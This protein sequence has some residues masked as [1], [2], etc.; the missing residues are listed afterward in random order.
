MDED[1]GA[2][3]RRIVET[4]DYVDE[5]GKLL[6]QV[7][8]YEPKD[9]RQ[10]RPDP[11]NAGQWLWNL[12]GVKRVPYRLPE[13]QKASMQDWTI[14]AEGEKDADRLCELGFT[15]TTCPMGAGKWSGD[16]NGYFK[17]RLVAIL[18]DNDEAGR[19]HTQRFYF[20]TRGQLDRL[21]G[22]SGGR[23]ML[24]VHGLEILDRWQ[25]SITCK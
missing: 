1:T 18:P 15:A 20:V 5:S 23:S 24:S 16:Y 12:D 7:V 21:N 17:G 10:R 22:V 9:F 8:R 3:G 6:F 11:D 25:R 2:F 4:Y 13:L 14:I 19:K